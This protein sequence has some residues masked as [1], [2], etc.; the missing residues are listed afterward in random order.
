MVAATQLAATS[1]ADWDVLLTTAALTMPNSYAEEPFTTLLGVAAA[2]QS[3]RQE[4]LQRG[5]TA[6][7]CH[8]DAAATELT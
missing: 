7:A 4:C 2:L 3:S 5:D 1:P 8:L 6:A